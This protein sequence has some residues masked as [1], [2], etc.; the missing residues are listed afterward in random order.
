MNGM[1]VLAVALVAGLSACQKEK[2]GNLLGVEAP[3]WQKFVMVTEDDVPL[4]K[5]ADPSSP[6]LLCWTEDLESDMVD[7][8]FKWD[9]EDKPADNY[10]PRQESMFMG[11]VLPV[12]SEEGDFYKVNIRTNW[13]DADFAYLP[14]ACA[15]DIATA[16]ITP[17]VLS[18]QQYA[19]YLTIDEGPLKG[20]CLISFLGDFDEEMFEVGQL[21]DS[22]I[23]IPEQ[24]KSISPL[25]DEQ[26]QGIAIE[27]D[28]DFPDIYRLKYGPAEVFKLGNP[29]YGD[30][31]VL[32]A[33]KL[34]DEQL[35]QVFDIA[36]NEQP[37]YVKAC[38]YFPDYNMYDSTGQLQEFHQLLNQR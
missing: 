13:R 24:R 26:Q 37:K 6:R 35:Q 3:Q 34:S 15:E 18:M 1:V 17:E 32:D 29:E 22:C 30:I 36:K 27:Q 20:L 19:R 9:D 14:K 33:S 12:V 16:P 38:Y 11:N 4:F 7:V 23:V 2:S 25:Y 31:N 10:I 5:E 8:Q 28:A 21:M